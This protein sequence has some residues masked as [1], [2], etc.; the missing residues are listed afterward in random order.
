MFLQVFV[1]DVVQF[2][3]FV[4][5]K[6]WQ[7]WVVVVGCKGVVFCDFDGVFNCF[8]QIC[9]EC[10]YFLLGFEIMLIGQM[11]MVVSLIY[12]GVFGDVNQCVVGFIYFGFGEIDVIG[13]DKWDVLCIGYFDKVV[14]CQ[15]FGLWC[16]VF[17]GVMLQFYIEVVVKDLMQMFYYCF[18]GGMLV[19]L[20]Q[21]ID[22]VVGVFGQID[23]I[24]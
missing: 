2:G 16:V 3:D 17:F 24:F 9:K 6:F 7:D 23:E 1:C 21:M 22:R 14:F 15:L 11:M 10:D 18:G 20:E 19:L 13:G 5:G 8:G 4:I 12:I